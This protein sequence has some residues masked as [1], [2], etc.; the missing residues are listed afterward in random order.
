MTP[1]GIEPKIPASEGPQT[2]AP[3]RAASGVTLITHLHDI[4]PSVLFPQ[5]FAHWP[6]LLNSLTMKHNST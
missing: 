4:I 3:D 5:R 6:C 2:H 1:V